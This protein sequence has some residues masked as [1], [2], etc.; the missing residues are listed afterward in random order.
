MI[1]NTEFLNSYKII[2]AKG[3]DYQTLSDRG[4]PTSP[5]EVLASPP[6]PQ[7]TKPVLSM[8]TIMILADADFKQVNAEASW[9]TT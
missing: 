3:R 5:S 7:E 1:E 6:V 2:F 9:N 8:G 4:I